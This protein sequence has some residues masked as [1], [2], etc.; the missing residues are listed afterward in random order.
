MAAVQ[1]TQVLLLLLPPSLPRVSEVHADAPVIL[2]GIIASIAAAI[3]FAIVPAIRSSGRDAAGPLRAV[4]A[5]RPARACATSSS[6]PK[7]RWRSR[8]SS[9]RDCSDGASSS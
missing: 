3:L 5:K 2:T 6:P 9:A 4:I 7:W 1:P 8:C